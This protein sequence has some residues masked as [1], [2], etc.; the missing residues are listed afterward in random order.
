MGVWEYG[1]MGVLEYGSM[2]MKSSF[3]CPDLTTLIFTFF[4]SLINY[5]VK[6]SYSHTPILPYSHTF[7]G[8]SVL[9]LSTGF[10]AAAFIARKLTVISAIAR[11]VTPDKINTHQLIGKRYA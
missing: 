3:S 6:V 10:A 9:R 1:S 7:L 11:A 8:Y 4:I 2:G 5:S